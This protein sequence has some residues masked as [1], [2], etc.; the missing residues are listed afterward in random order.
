MYHIPQLLLAL[1]N[2]Y[3]GRLPWDSYY[4]IIFPY[5]VPLHS[6]FQFPSVSQSCSVSPSLPQLVS[7]NHLL[8]WQ[9]E[10]LVLLFWSLQKPSRPSLVRYLLYKLNRIGDKQRPCLTSLSIF[11]SLAPVF[12][13]HFTSRTFLGVPEEQTS[14]MR[15]RSRQTCKYWEEMVSQ[16]ELHS[17][18]SGSGSFWGFYGHRNKVSFFIKWGEIC[19]MAKRLLASEERS[20]L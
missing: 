2:P 19:W 12:V 11:I 5:S 10:M 18:S 13:L 9:C 7:H 14:S 17:P 6:I 8:I 1:H 4:L 15:T 20:N 3:W 16:C